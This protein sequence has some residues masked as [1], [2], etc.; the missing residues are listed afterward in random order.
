MLLI[1]E[2]WKALSWF[3]EKK[4]I[5]FPTETVYGLGAMAHDE[6]NIENIF[7]IKNRPM[8]NPLIIHFSSIGE[9]KS[10]C[11]IN[12]LEDQLLKT[13]TPGPLT[14]LLKKKHKNTFSTATCHSDS[15]CVRIPNQEF[16]LNLIKEF[17]AIAA[18]SCN[19]STKLTITN[20][21][22]LS[23]EYKHINIGAYVE[24]SSVGGI[25]S[26]ILKVENN[27]VII[28]RQ[29]LITKE[30]I[31][32]AL[33]GVSVS[34]VIKSFSITPGSHFPHYQIKKPFFVLKDNNYF[35]I[36]IGNDLCDFN[37]SP[38]F[39]SKEII[40]NYFYSLFLGDISNLPAVSMVPLPNNYLFDG[41]RDR[42]KKTLHK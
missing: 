25:E 40:K 21:H 36:G 29:G 32:N 1:Y 37:L 34:K 15:I 9:I 14:L 4:L 31:E 24:D 38:S 2:P 17:G 10:C 20:S 12:I 39:N 30:E 6:E 16:A 27:S 28:L 19:F 41:L 22:M 23:H 5:I 3:K 33:P 7:R 8:T 11:H 35:H 42:L 13:F 18:P 26:T